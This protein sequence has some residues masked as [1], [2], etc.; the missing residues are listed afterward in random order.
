MPKSRCGAFI[1]R[2][3]RAKTRARARAARLRQPVHVFRAPSGL[4]VLTDAE[5]E[6]MD[7]PA[8]A[9]LVTYAPDGARL[10]F[11]TT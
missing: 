3:E 6:E 9:A 2:L 8:H 1:A 11:R 5:A 4:Y 7:L 10:F